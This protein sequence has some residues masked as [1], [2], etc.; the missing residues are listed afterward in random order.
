MRKSTA[1]PGFVLCMAAILLF[2]A[3]PLT[4]AA[5]VEVSGSVAAG[6]GQVS[7]GEPATDPATTSLDGV[8]EA[9]VNFAAEKGSFS[10][11]IELTVAE[12]AVLDGQAHEVVWAISTALSLTM[13]GQSFG[14]EPVDGNISVINTAGGQVGDERVA[15]DFAGTGLMNVEFTAGGIILGLALLDGCVPECG[16]SSVDAYPTDERMTS[17][18]H[19]RG[20]AGPLGYNVYAASSSGSFNMGAGN[21]LESG[22]GSG[23]GLGLLFETEAMTIGFDY[24]TATIVCQ[25][26]AGGTCTDDDEIAGFGVSASVAG[27]GI[28]YVSAENTIGASK[29]ELT[30]I[31]VVYVMEVGDAT[32]GPEYRSTTVDDGTDTSTD[33]FILFGMLLEF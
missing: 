3:A 18:L 23:A 13:S 6:F 24:A 5:G 25:Q 27:F 31:D 26:D 8:G 9:V 30:N 28:H 29:T 16:Y 19:L 11:Q 12:D 20:K 17:V 10:A 33:T 22:S 32:V 15:L 4:R 1:L 2:A 7:L 21:A 14:V